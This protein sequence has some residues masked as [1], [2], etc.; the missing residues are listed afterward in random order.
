MN[1]IFYA[2]LVYLLYRFITGFVLPVAKATSQVKKQFSAMHNQAETQQAGNQSRGR[3][4]IN[5]VDQKPK[6]DVEG[7]YIKFEEIK[8]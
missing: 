5:G 1:Y 4:S 8:D 7:E 3:S 6:Y 2:I